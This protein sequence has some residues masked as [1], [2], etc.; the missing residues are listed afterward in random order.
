[1]NPLPIDNPPVFSEPSAAIPPG[2]TP[3]A[4]GDRNGSKGSKPRPAAK[5]A[6]GRR[7]AVLLD[8]WLSVLAAEGRSLAWLVSAVVHL[9]V[10]LLLS[11]MMLAQPGGA[12]TNWLEGVV[13]PAMPETL[14]LDISV[15]P[16]SGGEMDVPRETI[17]AIPTSEDLGRTDVLDPSSLL[18]LQSPVSTYE[19]QSN[20]VES[21]GRLLAARG[22]GLEGRRYANRRRLALAGGGTAASE[23]AVERGLAWLAV[24]QFDDGGW[25]F[26]LEALPQC[27]GAC[28]NSGHFTSTTASTGLAL[29]CFLGAGY[30]QQEGPYQ[31][32]VAE[33]LYYLTDRMIVTSTGGDLRDGS[34][35]TMYAHGIA[36]LALCEA[37][38]MTGDKN[39]AEPAQLAV[40]F[41][42]DAQHEKGG[43]RYQ[44]GEPGDTTVTGWQITALKS[45]LLAKLHVPREVWYKA[46]DFLD[47]VQDDRG[48]TY[49]YVEP[50]KKR[51]TT[52]VVGL[53]SRMMLGWPRQHPPLLKGMAR[54]AAQAP[55]RNNIYFDYYASQAL[56]H[57]GGSGWKRWNPRMRTYLVGTQGAEGH[58]TGSWYFN[59][60]HSSPGGR[61]YTTSLAI[62]TLEVYYRYMPMYQEAFI[63]Q[64]P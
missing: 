38:A 17:R 29:L 11:L 33:G 60:A 9:C 31:Q 4:D 45:A 25:R 41:I 28:R 58:E 64:A 34:A 37:Y 35:G 22:G 15:L 13:K 27:A 53:F 7:L 49:G 56:H 46:S 36:T 55:Q 3:L 20:V 16:L 59:E 42:V 63:D 14:D 23:A 50:S 52:S 18:D 32:V 47:G 48:A 44:P 40:N 19:T 26:D 8:G 43:W 54:I 30:T 10:V 1:V 21:M 2:S 62:L 57:L 51:R 5:S 39:L 12:P 61:L 24:H 6:V